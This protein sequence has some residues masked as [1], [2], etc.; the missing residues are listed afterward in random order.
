MEAF[1]D[2]LNSEEFK[3]KAKLPDNKEGR[4]FRQ[5]KKRYKEGK[6]GKAAIIEILEANGYEIRADKVEKKIVASP[7]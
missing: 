3:L 7:S 4:R 6:L 2:F 1:Q 5:Y